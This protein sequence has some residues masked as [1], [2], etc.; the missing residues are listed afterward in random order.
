M[1]VFQRRLRAGMVEI[2]VG[3]LYLWLVDGQRFAGVEC[4]QMREQRGGE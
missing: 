1:V 2:D 3:E 4:C